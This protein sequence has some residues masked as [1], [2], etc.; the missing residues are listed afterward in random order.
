M[1]NPSELLYDLRIVSFHD[2]F[3]GKVAYAMHRTTG[4]PTAICREY[5][6]GGL[7]HE[8]FARGVTFIHAKM[9]QSAVRD[10]DGEA[11]MVVCPWSPR[12]NEL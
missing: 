11:E 7:A 3:P 1:T 5:V 2:R 6:N 4:M 8:L 10:A 9:I 12:V